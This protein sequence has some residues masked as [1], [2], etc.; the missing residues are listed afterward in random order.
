M[1]HIDWGLQSGAHVSVKRLA[2]PVAER[3][4]DQRAYNQHRHHNTSTGSQ[5]HVGEHVREPERPDETPG[6]PNKGDEH[7]NTAGLIRV[8]V[9]GVRNEHRCDNLVT[10]GGNAG[11]DDGC[12]VPMT[13]RCLLNAN[14][15][16]NETADCEQDTEVAQPQPPL[17]CR[18]LGSNLLRAS[19]HPHVTG[20]TTNLLA[21]D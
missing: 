16:N 12:D 4:G 17:G 15:E 13:F 19:T 10:C 7:T 6:L 5:P 14:Q 21:D 2:L 1:A 18:F 20:V 11:T 3:N 9:N 8:A